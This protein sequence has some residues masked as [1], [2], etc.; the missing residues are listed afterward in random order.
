MILRDVLK[1]FYFFIGALIGLMNNDQGSSS[2]SSIILS[3]PI[4]FLLFYLIIRE[5]HIKAPISMR[6]WRDMTEYL[7]GTRVRISKSHRH[8]QHQ[9]SMYI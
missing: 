3:Y 1:R 6:A 5:T 8:Y 4:S 9:Y 2:D 7:I